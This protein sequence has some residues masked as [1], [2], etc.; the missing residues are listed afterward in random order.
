LAKVLQSKSKKMN[1]QNFCDFF[2][3]FRSFFF[4]LQA[5]TVDGASGNRRSQRVEPRVAAPP[6]V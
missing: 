1:F 2:R 5:I 4:V 6:F 3:T